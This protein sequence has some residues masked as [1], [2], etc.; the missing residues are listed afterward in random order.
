MAVGYNHQ[1]NIG[2]IDDGLNILY[3][4]GSREGNSIGR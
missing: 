4:F 1:L 3:Y 2:I